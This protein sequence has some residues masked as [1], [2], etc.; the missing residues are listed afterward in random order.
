MGGRGSG[1]VV[2]LGMSWWEGGGGEVWQHRGCADGRV[3]V[4]RCG[5]TGDVLMGGWGWGSGGVA[6]NC[7]NTNGPFTHAS[8]KVEINNDP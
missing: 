7:A 4:W 5:S 6:C 3:G 1:G 2:A 8:T